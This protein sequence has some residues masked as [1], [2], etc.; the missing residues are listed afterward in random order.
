MKVYLLLVFASIVFVHGECKAE[1]ADRL[2]ERSVN[3]FENKFQFSRVKKNGPGGELLFED[4]N[5]LPITVTCF[6]LEEGGLVCLAS[7]APGR[8]VYVK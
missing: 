2:I 4:R 1:Q 3:E 6:E 8:S 7:G 5:N